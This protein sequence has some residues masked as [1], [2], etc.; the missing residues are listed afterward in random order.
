M[1]EIIFVDNITFLSKYYIRRVLMR[2]FLMGKL[3]LPHNLSWI[4]S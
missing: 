1:S 4:M 2:N 3:S